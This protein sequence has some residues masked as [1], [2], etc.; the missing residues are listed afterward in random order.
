MLY[1]IIAAA[2]IIIGT[3]FLFY[4][5][6]S[7][8]PRPLAMREL[9][10][11]LDLTYAEKDNSILEQL[12][13]FKIYD[14]TTLQVAAHNVLR[15]KSMP[16]DIWVFDYK[17]MTGMSTSTERVAHTVIYFCDPRLNL[18]GFRLFPAAADIGRQGEAVFKYRPITFPSSPQFSANYRLVGPYDHDIRQLFTTDVLTFF[19]KTKGICVEA[20]KNE[21]LVYQHKIIIPANKF[22]R[23]Y[24][25]ALVIFQ[26]LL[27]HSPAAN[28]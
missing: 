13:F 25:N 19:G 3:G 22:N 7:Q 17:A 27:Q 18:A 16:P 1:L 14:A 15:S 5:Y 23:F 2:G 9:G 4:R 6:S 28:T 20:F 21:V 11:A 8:K 12:K 10:G 24:Q 26:L